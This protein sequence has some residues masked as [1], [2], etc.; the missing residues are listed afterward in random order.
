MVAKL[1]NNDRAESRYRD[2]PDNPDYSANKRDNDRLHEK[3]EHDHRVFGADG[4]AQPHLLD[5][6]VDGKEHWVHTPHYADTERHGRDSRPKIL[7]C[8]CHFRDRVKP[9]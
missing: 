8:P 6:L 7:D 2:S 1:L 9:P 4:F 5:P 3:L